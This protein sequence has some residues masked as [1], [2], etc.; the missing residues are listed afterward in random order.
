M[1]APVGS[2]T[3]TTFFWLPFLPITFYPLLPRLVQATQ[4][5][6]A[7]QY[8]LLEQCFPITLTVRQYYSGSSGRTAKDVDGKKKS[9]KWTAVWDGIPVGDYLFPFYMR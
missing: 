4:S 6:R 5:R 7:S 1:L 2:W 9:N 3:K 8:V